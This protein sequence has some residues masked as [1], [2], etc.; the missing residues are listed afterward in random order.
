MIEP[1]LHPIAL[2]DIRPTQMTVGMREVERKRKKWHDKGS[3][4]D[5]EFL[6]RHMIPAVMWD[7]RGAG[8]R[9]D[10]RWT[11]LARR[12]SHHRNLSP[13]PTQEAVVPAI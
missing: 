10:Q 12:L 5:A 6:G 4:K 11:G 8:L 2:T 7:M 1:L 3:K 13:L 9:R